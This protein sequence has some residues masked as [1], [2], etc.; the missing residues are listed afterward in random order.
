[1]FSKQYGWGRSIYSYTNLVDIENIKIL[2]S[3]ENYRG[4]IPRGLGRSY[5]DSASNA[6]GITLTCSSLKS[7]EIDVSTG[8]ATLSSGVTIKEL[9]EKSLSLGFFPFVVPGTANISVGG[10]IASNVHGK[11]H[12]R[13]GSFSNHLLSIRLLTADGVER[14]LRPLGENSKL[15]WA[16]VGG[17]GLTGLILEATLQLQKIQNEFVAVNEVRVKNLDELLVTLMKFD[18]KYLYTVAWVDLSGN[19]EGR[20]R[21]SGANHIEIADRPRT[22][23]SKKTGSPKQRKLKLSNPFGWNLINRI[24]V[25]FFNRLWFYKQLGKQRQHVLKYL[26]PLDWID[27]WN[28]LYGKRGFIQYQFVVPFEKSDVLR[29]ILDKLR[30]EKCSSFLSVLKSFGSEPAAFLSFPMKGWSLAIDLPIGNPKVSKMLKEFDVLIVNAGGRIYL[31]KDSRMGPDLLPSMYPE[32]VTWKLI[33][34]EIDPSN[35]WQSDQARRLKLC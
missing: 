17:M 27:N 21:V 18:E 1:M 9:E 19:F 3:F 30:D 10:A 26:H 11:S 20:G 2:K 24:T 31:T 6:G 35:F 28:V 13:V 34:A 16:T 12:H 4:C 15:F 33:K 23:K 25:G 32:L 14:N 29:A 5:G 7:I 8:I 22:N